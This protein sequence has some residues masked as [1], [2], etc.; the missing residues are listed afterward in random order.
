MP[1]I[2]T[3]TTDFGLEDEYVGVM[4]G[5]IL[6]RAPN[7]KIIDLSHAIDR[8]NV[9]QAA[10]LI[11]SAYRFFPEKTIHLA[12]V[13]PGVGSNRKV[14]LLKVN[15]QY[16]L[17]PDNGVFALLLES[18]HFQTAYEVQC[19]Q[20]Y[21]TPVSSTFHG[22]DIMAPVAA[23]LSAGLDPE[24]TGP[25]IMPQALKKIAFAAA[26]INRLQSTITGEITGRDHFGNLLTNIEA[27]SINSLCDHYKS[28][29]RVTVRD[30]TIV[31]IQD[32]Y[33]DKNPGD[34]LALLGSRGFLEI[35][36]REGNAAAYLDAGTGDGVTVEMPKRQVA[37]PGKA[38]NKN[39]TN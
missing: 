12:V 38:K 7:V 32:A 28:R 33:A 31:G 36:V 18:E 27:E 3:M 15:E 29:T 39:V 10:L 14:V 4:K 9:R 22:R 11:N 1:R 24:D 35:T 17:G 13:D 20:Y 19:E 34:L 5:V 37:S 25:V 6:A 26:E 21:V 8:H 23:Q 30:K 16:F 2:I